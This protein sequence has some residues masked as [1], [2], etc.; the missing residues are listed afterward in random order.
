MAWKSLRGELASRLA[1]AAIGIPL[2]VLIIYRG[3]WTLGILMAL[4]AALGAREFYSVAAREARPLVGLGVVLSAALPL[5]ASFYPTFREFAPVAFGLVAGTALVALALVVW[6]RWPGGHPLAA[7]SSTV[8]GALYTG[9]TLAFWVLLRALP[10][11]MSG[12]ATAFHGAAVLIF[13]MTVT[14]VGDTFAYAFGSRWGRA[15]LIVAVSPRKTVVGAVGGLVGSMVAGG[16]YGWLWLSGGPALDISGPMA[17]AL[18][19]PI[20]MVG[21]VGDLAESVLKREAGV[22]DSSKLLPGHGGILDRLD[23]V[24]F[25]VPFTYGLLLVMRPWL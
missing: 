17:A 2:V 8:M 24:L 4:V 20:A 22:K 10:E 1:V 18:S 13:P 6:L 9:G 15:K 3:V 25:S 5:A 11:Q 19:A 23:A 7:S 12:Q 14:W 21:Q 16:V